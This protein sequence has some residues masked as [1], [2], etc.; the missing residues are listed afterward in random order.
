MN[1]QE[2]IDGLRQDAGDYAR[3]VAAGGHVD[4]PLSWDARDER[5]WE[6]ARLLDAVSKPD[7]EAFFVRYGHPEDA[8]RVLCGGR[9]RHSKGY[10]K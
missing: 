7:S 10:L 8:P 6:A 9:G 4:K 3:Y 1:L 5:A 2:L